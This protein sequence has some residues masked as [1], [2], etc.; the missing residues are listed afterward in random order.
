M[1]ESENGGGVKHLIISTLKQSKVSKVQDIESKMTKSV[2]HHHH[3][4]G[5]KQK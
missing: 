5:A 3:H 4:K 2:E 1:T